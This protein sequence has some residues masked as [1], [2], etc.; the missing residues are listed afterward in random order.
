MCTRFVG[1]S[2]VCTECGFPSR[3]NLRVHLALPLLLEERGEC[4]ARVGGLSL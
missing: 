2:Y 1:L 3:T 4:E